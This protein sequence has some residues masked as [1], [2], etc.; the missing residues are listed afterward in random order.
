MILNILIDFVYNNIKVNESGTKVIL[1]TKVG[2]SIIVP[3]ESYIHNEL[4]NYA[5]S[6]LN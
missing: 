6:R 4:M 3:I 5:T 1:T 2:E